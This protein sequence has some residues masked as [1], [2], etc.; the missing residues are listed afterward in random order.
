[1]THRTTTAQ[2]TKAEQCLLTSLGKDAAL[3]A[4]NYNIEGEGA[5]FIAREF[6][7]TWREANSLIN[8][9]RKLDATARA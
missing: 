1:M 6:D 7:I 2:F 4:Y 5:Y 3:K 8:A 9:G